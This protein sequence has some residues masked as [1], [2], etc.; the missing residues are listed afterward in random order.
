MASAAWEKR[1]ARARALGYRSYY[2]YRAHNYGKSR[3]RLSGEALRLLRGH[4][5]PADLERAIRSG[6]VS[7]L[8]QEPVGDR[9]PK[10]GRYKEIR[11]TAQLSD[12]S[13]RRYR[14]R[15]ASPT[16]DQLSPSALKQ[17]R[18]AIADGGADVYTNPSVDVLGVMERDD[19]A[20]A[21]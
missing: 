18:A 10:T 3:D 9:D 11:V 6:R 13:Q 17:L 8:S 1:N 20:E 21:V 16:G 15:S 19:L 2:D 12:G 14:L 5:G 4:A 7:V